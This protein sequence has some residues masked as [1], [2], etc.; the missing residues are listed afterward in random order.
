[1]IF[2]QFH[3]TTL[4]H[5]DIINVVREEIHKNHI[6]KVSCVVFHSKQR[7]MSEVV[8]LKEIEERLAKKMRVIGEQMAKAIAAEIFAQTQGLLSGPHPAQKNVVSGSTTKNEPDTTAPKETTKPSSK[9]TVVTYDH[10]LPITA[11]IINSLNH[12]TMN[13]L[14]ARYPAFGSMFDQEL[15]SAGDKERTIKKMKELLK[16]WK[17]GEK[18]LCMK[19]PDLP[20]VPKVPSNPPAKKEEPLKD[21]NEILS[22][23]EKEIASLSNPPPPANQKA[24][25]EKEATT[26][27][28]PQPAKQKTNNQ[29]L[30]KQKEEEIKK[31]AD[32]EKEQARIRQQKADESK[33]AKEAKVKELLDM[34]KRIEEEAARKLKEL[35]ESMKEDEEVEEEAD[36]QPSINSITKSFREEADKITKGASEPLDIQVEEAA[37]SSDDDAESD[38][39]FQKEFCLDEE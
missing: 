13:T 27:S 6:S 10:G 15:G 22:V 38:N 24:K 23:I 8:T 14:I 11:V 37:P 21:D 12:E 17:D 9:R 33:K 34:R 39:D 2:Y 25:D 16:R 32:F 3:T 5:F 31:Q 4:S 35:E 1:M 18:V 7:K 30:K 19:Y 28:K 26:V 20:E 29:Q 36:E